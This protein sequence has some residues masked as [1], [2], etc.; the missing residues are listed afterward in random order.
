M[1]GDD[2]GAGGG[3]L[4][5]IAKFRKGG[6]RPT[7]TVHSAGPQNLD[8]IVVPKTNVRIFDDKTQYYDTPADFRQKVRRAVSDIF[9]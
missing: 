2:Q 6:L 3:L 8:K 7:E 9:L 5:E 1:E 4:G